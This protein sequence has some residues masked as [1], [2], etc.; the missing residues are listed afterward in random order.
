MKR[1][2]GK[3]VKL[4][5]GT[6]PQVAEDEQDITPDIQTALTVRK[7]GTSEAQN[8]IDKVKLK[9]FLKSGNF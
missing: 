1:W 8:D 4:L 2:N 6:E 3:P 7:R 9:N 5:S